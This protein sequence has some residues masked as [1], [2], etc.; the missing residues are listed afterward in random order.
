MWVLRHVASLATSVDPLAPLDRDVI[1]AA[2]LFHD[3]IYDPQ[4]ATN[5]ADSAQLAVAQ[6]TRLGWA[7][8]RCHA[9]A[10]LIEATAGHEASTPTSAVLLDADLA[11]LGGSPPDYL[12]YV[13]GV[14]AEYA[15]VGDDVWRIGRAAVLR[16]FLDR[17]RIFSTPTMAHERERQARWN[18]QAELD[19]LGG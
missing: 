8:D 6:L 4:S 11:V 5:E 15:H 7:A 16:S 1:T 9:V 14:R 18:L 17:S 10:A 19:T 12:A 13:A 3:V 2:A